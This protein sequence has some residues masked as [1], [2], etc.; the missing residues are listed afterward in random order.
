MTSAPRMESLKGR[1]A[2][3]PKLLSL[4]IAGAACGI[5]VVGVPGWNGALVALD[6]VAF[7]AVPV[8]DGLFGLGADLPR[9]S[10]IIGI[11]GLLSPPLSGVFLFHFWMIS[12]VAVAFTGTAQRLRRRGA[13]T[14]VR[15]AACIGGGLLYAWNPYLLTRIGVG[16]LG[17]ATAYALLPWSID[18]LLNPER[19]LQRTFRA[20]AL[21]ALCGYFG[22]VL[23][24]PLV[25]AGIIANRGRG[26]LRVAPLAA[27]SQMPWLAPA[28]LRIRQTPDTASSVAFA[29]DAGG[30]VDAILLVGGYGFWQR[31]NQVGSRHPG[32]IAVAL[33]LVVLAVIGHRRSTAPNRRRLLTVALV[34]LFLSWISAIP[35]LESTYAQVTGLAPLAPLREGQRLAA[36]FLVWLLPAAASGLGVLAASVR[37]P[38]LMGLLGVAAVVPVASSLGGLDGRVRPAAVPEAW[39]EARE[40]SAGAGTTLV[41]PFNQYFDVEIAGDRRAH[42][43]L[44]FF[45]EGDVL[46]SHDPQLSSG[47]PETADRRELGLSSRLRT[48]DSSVVKELVDLGVRHIVVLPDVA[49]VQIDPESI[50]DAEVLLTDPTIVVVSLDAWRGEILGVGDTPP[51]EASRVFP[52][53]YRIDGELSGDATWARHAT[54]GWRQGTREVKHLDNGLLGLPGGSPNLVFIPALAII[55]LW[56]LWGGVALSTTLPPTLLPTLWPARMACAAVDT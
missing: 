36:I 20:L 2:S 12:I 8:P 35:Q 39:N 27:F 16:H 22:A 48:L 29:T 51:L 26:L 6:L 43:P 9:R 41:L 13:P 38:L 56:V 28:L 5:A 31:S 37:R 7:E 10:P 32:V 40:L 25:L 34:C 24:A 45:L 55:A 21:F 18:T 17:F 4:W 11:I 23:A 46:S 3:A 53:W 14:T 19:D 1:A 44:P 49:L 15:W 52:F 47:G 42:N 50:P 33:L 54:D 30:V